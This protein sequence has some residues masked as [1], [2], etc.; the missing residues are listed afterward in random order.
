MD[1]QFHVVTVSAIRRPEST[2]SV[3]VLDR[4]GM[5][6]GADAI[7]LEIHVSSFLIASP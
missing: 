1:T 5:D 2:R 7:K 3:A 4:A 6:T